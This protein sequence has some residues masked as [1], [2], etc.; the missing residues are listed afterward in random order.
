[1]SARPTV[2]LDCETTSLRWDREPWEIAL[3]RRE[4]DG[5]T[6]E[7]H[8]FLNVSLIRADPEALR[9]GGY[10]KRHLRRQS[11]PRLE[12]IKEIADLTAGATI[13]GACPWFDTETLETMM[14]EH[15][16]DPGWHHRLV[17]VESLTAGHLGRP[18]GGLAACLEALG[19]ENTAPHTAMGDALAAGDIYDHIITAGSGQDG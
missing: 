1:M 3:I 8:W 4:P 2:F 10:F 17:C 11:S 16:I 18:V 9:I 14:R 7:H 6:F 5:C 19:L 12:V 13:V 15:G